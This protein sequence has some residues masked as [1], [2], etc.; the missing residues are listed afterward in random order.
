Y[1]NCGGCGGSGAK[2]GTKP[3]TCPTCHGAGQVRT[4]QR[5]ILGAFST[6][7]TCAACGGEGTIVKDPCTECGGR[8]QTRKTR[9]ISV[10][11]PAGIDNGQ[12]LTLRSEGDHGK[13]GGPPGDLYLLINVKNHEIFKRGGYDVYLDLP[14]TFVEA[15]LGAE[16]DVPTLH[17]GVKLKIPEGTQTGTSFRIRGKGIARL[18]GNGQGDQFVKVTID[19]PKRLTEKQ[20]ELLKSFGA[21]VG[22]REFGGRKGFFGKVKDNLG[23]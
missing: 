5:T 21:S 14:I 19:V 12:Q 6:V 3:Q 1:E 9:N 16:I 17:G 11:I 8:G 20:K 22:T 18:G 10:K 23:I 13:K 15:A 2:K 4:S 7:T